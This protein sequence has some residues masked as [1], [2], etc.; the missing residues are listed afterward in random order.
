MFAELNAL[1]SKHKKC[2]L[3]ESAL[4]QSKREKKTLQKKHENLRRKFDLLNVLDQTIQDSTAGK[5]KFLLNSA[6]PRPN[7]LPTVIVGGGA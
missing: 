5:W 4:K 1:R 2:V 6:Q 7:T 3:V